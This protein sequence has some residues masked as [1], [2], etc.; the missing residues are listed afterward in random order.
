MGGEGGGGGVHIYSRFDHQPPCGH[1]RTSGLQRVS[2][3]LFWLCRQLPKHCRDTAGVAHEQRVTVGTSLTHLR[4]RV[5]LEWCV[6]KHV[7]MCVL[8]LGPHPA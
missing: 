6:H 3:P 7:E 5:R 2:S 8:Y 4:V 1:V